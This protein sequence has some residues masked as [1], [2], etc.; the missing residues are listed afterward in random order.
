MANKIGHLFAPGDGRF[1]RLALNAVQPILDRRPSRHVP[2]RCQRPFVEQNVGKPPKAGHFR[3]RLLHRNCICPD[4]RGKRRRARI[5]GVTVGPRQCF[6]DAARLVEAHAE[7]VV[8]R[9][10]HAHID[11]RHEAGTAQAVHAAQPLDHGI[12]RRQVANQM[13]GVEVHSDLAGRGRD[14]EP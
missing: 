9:R 4:D 6:Q 8:F 11:T 10:R 5:E 2:Y 12:E 1:G 14:K 13:I 3:K 7:V